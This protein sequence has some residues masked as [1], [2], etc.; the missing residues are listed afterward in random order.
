[1]CTDSETIFYLII[2]R[3]SVPNANETQTTQTLFIRKY[4]LQNSLTTNP[5][6]L[7][8]FGCEGFAGAA[9]CPPPTPAA[10]AAAEA[11]VAESVAVVAGADGTI[12]PWLA[13]ST[14][15]LSATAIL[16][17]WPVKP[18]LRSSSMAG[19]GP[20]RSTAGGGRQGVRPV[21]HGAAAG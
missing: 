14:R 17:S 15:S 21:G 3:R 1:M 19:W 4:T 13:A 16:R 12:S 11:A 7:T 6:L 8:V 9:A 5:E 20:S 10:A 2:T 18:L